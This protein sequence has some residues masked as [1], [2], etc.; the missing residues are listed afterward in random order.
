MNNFNEES[1]LFEET[2]PGG[3]NFSHILKRGTSIRITDLDGGAN[4]SALFYNRENFHERYNMADTL[5]AQYTSYLTKGHALY[6]DMGRILVSII[7][8]TYGWHDTITACSTP[9][10][11]LKKYGDKK[12]QEY[13]NA[14]HRDAHTSLLTEISKYGMRLND[15]HSMVNFFT[16]INI[17]NEGF[18]SYDQKNTAGSYIDLQAEM[19]TLVVLNSCPHPLNPMPEYDPKTIKISIWKSECPPEENPV[20]RSREENKRGFINTINYHK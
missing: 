13:R 7:E 12:Y 4:V 11:N 2:I 8:D 1:L 6:S 18:L 9:E 14:Y 20:Y 19:D 3:W 17:D 10:T 15:M 5:K 16:R